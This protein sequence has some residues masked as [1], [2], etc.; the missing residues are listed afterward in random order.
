M[1]FGLLMISKAQGTGKTALAERVLAP[2]LGHRNVSWPSSQTFT[3]GSN[4]WVSR[5]R[6]AVASELYAGQTEKTYNALK[7]AMTDAFVEVNIK[8]VPQHSIESVVHI[9]A[10]SNSWE[11]LRMDRGDRRWFVPKLVEVPWPR[12]KF[13]EVFDWLA[14]G[15]LMKVQHWAD[16]Y[17][18]YFANGE[19]APGSRS[20]TQIAEEGEP[21]LV[22]LILRFA[23]RF[24]EIAEPKAF[25][26]SDAVAWAQTSVADRRRV[27]NI[28]L[29]QHMARVGLC[30][31]EDAMKMHGSKEWPI[32][33]KA[34]RD[35]IAAKVEEVGRD[36][37]YAPIYVVGDKNGRKPSPVSEM[38][39]DNLV[40]PALIMDAPL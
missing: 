26:L 18:E 10:C 7:A 34:M 30:P 28:E 19:H 23:D 29:R 25:L 37:A 4:T 5:K 39:R 8:Y 31:H 38:I 13:A 24:K 16:S 27:G 22:K 9:Y 1:G 3:S 35:A 21:D 20:K 40:K 15:G 32:Y 33:N 14:A 36:A 12:E 2:L 6:L 11:A 17:G